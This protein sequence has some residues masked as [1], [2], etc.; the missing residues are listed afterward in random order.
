MCDSN[1]VFD[2]SVEI[3]KELGRYSEWSTDSTY[4]IDLILLALKDLGFK[5]MTPKCGQEWILMNDPSLY[6]WSMRFKRYNN[7]YILT[8]NIYDGGHVFK[9]ESGDE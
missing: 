2:L 6:Q 5:T 7:T 3:L 4:A 9:K 8:G 1:D